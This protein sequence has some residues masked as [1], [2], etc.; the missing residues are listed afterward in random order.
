MKKQLSGVIALLGA[1]VIWGSAFI[2][3][4][5]GM[6][7]IGPFT[8]QAVR[9]FLAVVFL[10][11]ASALFSKG[12]PFWKSWA[13]PALWRSGVICGLALF[14]ASS[15]QQIGLVY[16]D[17]GKAG[18]LTAMY[19]VFV[20]FL[21]LFLGQRPGRN[22]LL[23]LIPAIVGLYLLSCT[24]VSGINKGDVLLL[25]C[26]VA[27]SVQILLIDRHCAGLDGLKLNC[28]Q[29]LVAAVLSVPWALLTETVDASLIA[30][31]WLPLG[32]A[33]ILSMGVAYTLQ[34]VG[35][36]GVAP[37][38]AALLMSLESVFAA[39]FGWLLLH[40]TMTKAEVL[41]CLLVF[42]AVVISQLPEKKK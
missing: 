9:C 4:S 31:C 40:E 18:F 7:K 22:A 34:I 12:K 15:L 2:A 26:A 35:Q 5:V 3:Q 33:G 41:G 39:L 19:I 13:D 21:G 16:T 38:A 29:A 11:P 36:K 32:Y 23:S 8:F 6:D 42:A 20:P 10:F 14:A 28:I 30:A 24:S 1:T 27:F 17:A 25:L 37:S